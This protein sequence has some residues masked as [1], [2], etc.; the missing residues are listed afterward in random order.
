MTYR[1]FALAL[2][3]GAPAAAYSADP[4][5][6]KECCCCKEGV[7]GKIDCCKK[8]K[9]S[10]DGKDAHAGHDMSDTQQK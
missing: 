3:V 6:K 10:S 8:M 2:I 9:D 5:P 1:L 7:Q 4:A